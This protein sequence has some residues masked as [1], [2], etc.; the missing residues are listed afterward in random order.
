M[1]SAAWQAARRCIATREDGAHAALGV[2]LGLLLDLAQHPHRLVA[3]LVLDV[4]EQRL[5]GLP[6]AEPGDALERLLALEAQPFELV[7]SRSQVLVAALELGLAPVQQRTT[8][9]ELG[10]Q[11]VRALG[12]ALQLGRAAMQLGVLDRRRHGRR[13]GA[14]AGHGRHRPGSSVDD[15][16]DHDGDADEGRADQGFHCRVLSPAADGSDAL[17]SGTAVQGAKD[18]T[19]GEGGRGRRAGVWPVSGWR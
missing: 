15:R 8:A 17:V 2:A 14:V 3:R 18:R 4:L 19:T 9:I 16:G 13:H 6:G 1:V 7:L 11:R 10:L 12:A 5:L